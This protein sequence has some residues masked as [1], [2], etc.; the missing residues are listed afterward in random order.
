MTGT[1]S[2]RGKSWNVKGSGLRWRGGLWGDESREPPDTEDSEMQRDRERSLE[3]SLE[4]KI[5]L[6]IHPMAT[7]HRFAER[8]IEKKLML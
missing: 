6:F 5:S 3:N 2:R 7:G 1:S 4:F 8:A